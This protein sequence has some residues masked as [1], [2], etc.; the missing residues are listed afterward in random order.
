MC[1]VHCIR[2]V[3]V[4]SPAVRRVVAQALAS[5]V[6]KIRP[7]VQAACSITAALSV[8]LWHGD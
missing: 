8:Y 1:K 7:S 2:H 5:E 6:T 3:A 4:V